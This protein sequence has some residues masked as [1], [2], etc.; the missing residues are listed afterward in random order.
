MAQGSCFFVIWRRTAKFMAVNL[1]SSI[2][3]SSDTVA[4]PSLGEEAK[5][6]RAAKVRD[7]GST[8]GAGAVRRHRRQ[9]AAARQDGTELE[10]RQDAVAD[11]RP[12]P[13]VSTVGEE[14]CA[15]LSAKLEA[16]GED[17]A[18][19]LAALSG[20]VR[21]FS[22]DLGG[23]RVVQ[24]A[25]SVAGRSDA[26]SLVGELRGHVRDGV[27]S[28]A[29]NYVIQKLVEVMPMSLVEFVSE[30]LEGVGAVTA[31]HRFGCRVLCRL[32]EHHPSDGNTG[33]TA[34]LVSEVMESAASL[35]CHAYGHH[36]IECALEHGTT[37]QKHGI[38]EALQ[39]NIIRNAKNRF[40]SYV[41]RKAL[42]FCQIEDQQTLASALFSEP[43]KFSALA[44]NQ[45]GG[46][47]VR[48][49]LKLPP[50]VTRPAL[51]NLPCVQSATSKKAKRVLHE[52]HLLES[53]S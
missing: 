6:Q 30:E 40:A 27:A 18:A 16:G 50:E 37:E 5:V 14:L 15:Q 46:F 20:R 31:R 38:A 9:R 34:R 43:T 22:F 1:L 12:A 44:E 26:A 52:L 53:A 51:T 8:L 13:E 2:A 35:C 23:C 28:P 7:G 25:L 45:Y 33:P 49:L 36:V 3:P 21:E 39:V 11:E 10:T 17:R 48:T 29:G 4:T 41:L 32:L 19:A 47:V 42:L 24:L